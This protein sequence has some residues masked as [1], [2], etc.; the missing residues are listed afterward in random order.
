MSVIR[1]NHEAVPTH[2]RLH[3]RDRLRRG[4]SLTRR[5]R[6]VALVTAAVLPLAMALQVGAGP[7]ATA[8]VAPTGSGFTV[9]AGDLAFILKQIKIAERHASTCTA[10]NPCGTL[11]GSGARTRFPTASTSFGLRTV[12]GSCNNLFAGRETFAAADRPFPRHANPDFR[13]AQGG[14]GFFGP[15]SPAIASS[16]Y[17]QKKGDVFDRSPARSAT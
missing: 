14:A 4:T 11:V 16:S 17:A 15:G 13:T 6:L 12:D 7:A 10:A 2:G 9:T 8:A 3:L 1:R 5:R